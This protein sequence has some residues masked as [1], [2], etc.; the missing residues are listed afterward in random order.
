[1]KLVGQNSIQPINEYLP[2]QVLSELSENAAKLLMEWE[3][4]KDIDPIKVFKRQLV[5]LRTGI[6]PLKDGHN[7]YHYDEI[8]KVNNEAKRLT[9]AVEKLEAP[10]EDIIEAEKARIEEIKQAKI[11]AD[12][13]RVAAIQSKITL[14]RELPLK[15]VNK[16]AEYI[17]E[18]IDYFNQVT[19]EPF[20]YEE[21]SLD[22]STVQKE[23]LS[24][25]NIM[26]EE[27]MVFETQQ[28]AAA[29][30]T[31]ALNAFQEVEAKRQ[32]EEAIAHK[33]AQEEEDR[34]LI[35]ERRI[36]AEEQ[37]KIRLENEAKQAAIDEERRR[38]TAEI[39]AK[40]RELAEQQR[41]INEEK[42][43][44]RLEKEAE[45]KRKFEEGRLAERQQQEEIKVFIDPAK[46]GPEACLEMHYQNGE[47][48]EVRAFRITPQSV[49]DAAP[50]MFALLNH[51]KDVLANIR[52]VIGESMSDVHGPRSK[53]KLETQYKEAKLTESRIEEI[54]NIAK[55][56]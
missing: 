54:I 29:A 20:D 1:M 32:A 35:E 34:R 26:L 12:Q 38:N 43:R 36:F 9:A 18:T 2:D 14:I 21:L 4:G 17:K 19:N 45:E 5:S 22:A 16:S 11:K 6:K 42:E 48:A 3:A 25:L 40:Q 28:A 13:E 10:L 52:G 46:E 47:L 41:K 44:I 50:E 37:Q 49:Y 51:I 53:T 24:K 31:E 39:E 23:T 7:K 56:I 33:R 27:R 55:G 15:C 8:E 30:A